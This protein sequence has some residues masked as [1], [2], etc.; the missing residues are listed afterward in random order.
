VALVEEPEPGAGLHGLA[1]VVEIPEEPEV[2]RGVGEASGVGAAIGAPICVVAW[3]GAAAG[4]RLGVVVVLCDGVAEVAPAGVLVCAPA[5][6]PVV[7]VWG[8]EAV[9]N[10]N[11][12]AIEKTLRMR[13]SVAPDD[14]APR[15]PFEIGLNRLGCG[16]GQKGGA[17]SSVV[18]SYFH[19]LKPSTRWPITGFA[20]SLHPWFWESG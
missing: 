2:P 1:T 20:N 18:L 15:L 16:L 10:M 6:V 7:V 13:T 8:N 12:N 17:R 9:A 14:P 5:G 3:P 19:R 4:L 11:N